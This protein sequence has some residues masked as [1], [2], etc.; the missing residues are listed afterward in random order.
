[1]Q[2]IFI[3]NGDRLDLLA[4]VDLARGDVLIQGELAGIS[5]FDTPAG[6][7]GSL[8]VSG[9]FG[10]TRAPAGPAIAPG[11]PVYWDAVTKVATHDAGGG[12]NQRL[13]LSVGDTPAGSATVR[14]LL[15]H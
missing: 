6:G 1:M 15:N 13:G 2:A 4:P 14:V 11:N 3:Q 12:A 8:A 7:L 9:V 10:I 5:N